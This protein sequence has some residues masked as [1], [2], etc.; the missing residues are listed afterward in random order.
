[1]INYLKQILQD[2]NH[3]YSIREFAILL[4][5]LCIIISWI[6]QQFLQLNIPEFMFY[7]F[8]SLVAAGCFGYSIEKKST[9]TNNQNQQQ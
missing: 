8:V 7:G 9:L 4:F 6:A 3:Q 5:I 1:M 2:K